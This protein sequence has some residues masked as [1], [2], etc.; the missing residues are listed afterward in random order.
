MEIDRPSI[1]HHGTKRLNCASPLT[2][3][4]FERQPVPSDPAYPDRGVGVDDAPRYGAVAQSFHWVI[5]LLIGVQLCL[6]LL[7]E[8]LPLGLA[9][10]TMLARHK[11]VGMIVLVLVIGRLG[12]RFIHA[13]PPLPVTL[14]KLERRMAASAHVALYGLSLALPMSGWLLSSTTSH[15]LS[16][17]GF[18]SVPTLGRLDLGLLAQ[19]KRLHWL[20]G[21]ALGTIVLLHVAGALRHHFWLKDGILTRMLPRRSGRRVP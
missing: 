20:L 16:V 10:V 6:G 13:P 9:K 21:L 3:L 4:Q 18:I 19:L 1:L 12:W 7:A 14:S 2:S 8:Q 17:F 5:A 15:T 11:S